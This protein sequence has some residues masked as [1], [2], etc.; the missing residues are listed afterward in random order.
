M[1]S[2][3]FVRLVLGTA[4]LTAPGPLLGGIRAPDRDDRRV[5]VMSRLLGGRLVLQGGV[6]LA[7]RG[8]FRRVGTVVEAAHATSLLPLVALSPDHRRTA[9]VSAAL[10]LGLVLLDV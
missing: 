3:T 8:R 10:A 1:R 5:L 9:S 2:A 6:D 7:S 4:L